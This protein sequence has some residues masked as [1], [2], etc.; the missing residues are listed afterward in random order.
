MYKRVLLS[1]IGALGA[2]C[3]GAAGAYFTAQIQV[4]DSVIRSGAVA[5]STVPT[6]A[7][8]A[9]DAL[10]PGETAVRPLAVVNDGSLPADISVSAQKKAGVTDFF[11]QLT[12]RVSCNG[13]ELYNGALSAMKT[14]PLRLASGARGD[15][16]FE[17]GLP[18]GVTNSLAG[19]YAKVS[20]Y[21]D[22]EQAH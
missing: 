2:L 22:A 14:A 5:I 3:I 7:P 6:T 13:T 1:A 12:V 11:N 4:A 17:L 8:L 18:A 20:L 21:V 10:A 9:I 16:K 19:E 15:L